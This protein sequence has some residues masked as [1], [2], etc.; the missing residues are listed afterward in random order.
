MV[1]STVRSLPVEQLTGTAENQQWLTSHLG[2]LIDE[3]QMNVALTRAKHG[4]VI[5]G[6]YSLY[7][8]RS[9]PHETGSIRVRALV[10]DI[11]LCF[12]FFCLFVFFG[13]GGGGRNIPNHFILQKPG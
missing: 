1:L 11:V 12:F 8:V 13:G 3:R 4:L 9:T 10:G 2:F 5:I 7:F 6:E